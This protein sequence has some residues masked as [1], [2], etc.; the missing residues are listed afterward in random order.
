VRIFLQ[1]AV[2]VI[3]VFLA[4]L[5]AGLLNSVLAGFLLAIAFVAASSLL[6]G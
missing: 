6:V 1:L 5:L 3:G 4:V 2:A